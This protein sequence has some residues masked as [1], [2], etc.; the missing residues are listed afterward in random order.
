MRLLIQFNIGRNNRK[1][2]KTGR[3]GQEAE[4][5][6]VK[7]GIDLCGQAAHF[8]DVQ[9]EQQQPNPAA[10]EE[11]EAAPHGA[12]KRLF[13][14]VLRARK[15]LVGRDTLAR[16]KSKLQFI[17]ITTDISPG[18]REEVLRDFR[19]YPVVQAFSSSDLENFFSVRNAKVIGFAKSSLATSIYAELKDCRLNAPEP[20]VQIPGKEKQSRG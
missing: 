12:A 8:S 6:F 5:L 17:L 10:E 7:R 2:E 18:S 13:P 19:S 9:N 1:V 14:F 16:S 4:L 20:G 15:L 3:R 11:R